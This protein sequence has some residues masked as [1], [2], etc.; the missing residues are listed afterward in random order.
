LRTFEPQ[1]TEVFNLISELGDSLI[2][3]GD[4]QCRWTNIHAC[5]AGAETKRHTKNSDCSFW[6]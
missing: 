1:I 5:H 3:A 4:S 6:F 2:E